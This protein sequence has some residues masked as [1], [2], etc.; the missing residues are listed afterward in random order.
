MRTARSAIFAA[1]RA[2][3][4]IALD[5][6]AIGGRSRRSRV[7][8][9][10]SLR[11]RFP[12]RAADALEAVIVNTAGGMT[13][14]DRFSIALSVAPGAKLTACTAAAEKIYRSTG[15]DAEVKISL[16]V[17][18]D[19]RLAWLPQETILFDGSRLA[20]SHEVSVAGEGRALLFDSLVFGRTHSGES[21][22]RGRLID[23]WN[24]RRDGR[25]LW[26]DCL[27]LDG[28]IAGLQQR[29]A[30][31]GGARATGTLLY[32]SPPDGDLLDRAREALAGCALRC[33]A[34]LLR[35]GLLLCR[36]LAGDGA[37]LRAGVVRFLSAFRPA[38]PGLAPGLPR[39]W[40]C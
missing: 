16:A 26:T 10:G 30:L 14:G 8:E 32:L 9:E 23:R 31:L 22:T 33:G 7:H 12:H 36:F 18:D 2:R 4:Q 19:A 17:C 27:R 35:P 34:T 13:G 28:D 24:V 37:A 25:L 3:G 11:V 39:L 38:L 6:D 20:R 29:P 40:S 5:V 15:D 1:N 21:L